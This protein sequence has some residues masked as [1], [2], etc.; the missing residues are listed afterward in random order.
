MTRPC[1]RRR[2]GR[3]AFTLIEL[4]V[5][6]A[7]IAVLIGLLVPAVQKVRAAAARAQ[8]SNNMKQLGLAL[9][10]HHEALGGF[11]AGV[12]I[13]P[14]AAQHNWTAQ[15][16]PFLEQDNLYK[17][18]DFNVN[19]SAAPNDTGTNQHQIKEFI[20]PAAPPNRVGA[21]NRGI[22]DYPAIN[23]L[24][25]PNPYATRLPPSDPTFIGVLGKNVR[26]RIVEIL[27]GSSGTLVLAEDAGRNED[28]EMG[29][30]QGNLSE[31][32]AWAN[33]GGNI[34]V[35][36]FNPVSKTIPGPVAINGCNAQNVYSF[37]TN[38]AN[39]LFGDGSVRLL[40]TAMSLDVLIALTTRDGGE[41]VADD[42]F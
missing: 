21:N 41:V 19:W 26:R 38:G 8:C 18:Y 28:W 34:T 12:L 25:R 40:S 37:H 35:S 29:R 13:M 2:G 32:G 9:H 7:I 11:P 4:L 5:V 27:D 36:G 15:V 33:P 31:S 22:L 14:N 10:N 1:P 24:H 42:S 39:G 30:R 23:E 16:L 20:C 3:A 6:I 17:L